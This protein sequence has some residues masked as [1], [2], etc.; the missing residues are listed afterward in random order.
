MTTEREIDDLV[1]EFEREGLISCSNRPPAF[2]PYEEA[3]PA[4]PRPMQTRFSRKKSRTE[5]RSKRNQDR[6]RKTGQT[7]ADHPMD[8][9]SSAQVPAGSRENI[10]PPRP[11]YLQLVR[12]GA[13]L[14]RRTKQF[15]LT[16]PSLPQG[17]QLI[18]SMTWKIDQLKYNDHNTNDHGKFP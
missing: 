18:G 4:P 13:K 3:H 7:P 8:P 2:A 16:T 1:R 9:T 5:V 17:V 12:P 10:A 6:Q 11:P 14:P 15:T